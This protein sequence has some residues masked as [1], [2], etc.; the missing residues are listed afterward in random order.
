MV[1]YR[2]HGSWDK[3]QFIG[4]GFIIP[5]LDYVFRIWADD[6]SQLDF[7]DVAPEG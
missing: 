5:E 7:A 4:E 3:E 6:P 1:W 2:N